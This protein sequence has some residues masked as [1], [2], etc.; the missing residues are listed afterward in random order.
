M[1]GKNK[2]SI[3]FRQLFIFIISG[4]I[5]INLVQFYSIEKNTRHNYQALYR[6][7]TSNLFEIAIS[8]D[9][10]A[11]RW[12][13]PFYYFG[14]IFPGSDIIIPKKGAR[15]WFELP[16]A[17]VTFGQARDIIYMDY[18]PETLAN[19]LILKPY[20]IDISKYV[21]SR[22][23][24][25]PLLRQRLSILAAPEPSGT[26][27]VVT[28]DGPPG[29]DGQIMFLDISLLNPELLEELKYVQ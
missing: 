8:R 13:G 28:P 15:T 23:P 10:S 26:F 11:R 17:M 27:L 18:D 1:K 16:L 29:R 20:E 6:Y 2:Y 24:S 25:I 9:N 19:E 21:P 12:V 22:G 14:Q 7:E 3:Q 4:A 5:L